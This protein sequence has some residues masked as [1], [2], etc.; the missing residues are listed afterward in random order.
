[1]NKIKTR[2]IKILLI[3][4]N[5]VDK[6][7]QEITI[8]M[9]LFILLMQLYPISI[10]AINTFSTNASTTI[11]DWGLSFGEANTRPRGNVSQKELIKYNSY[12]IG[13]E[14]EKEKIIY[15]TFDAGYENGN[16]E[17][18]LNI[19]KEEE[20]PAA[21]FLVGHY[22]NT[23]PELVKRMTEDGH[24]VGNHT[25][26]HPDMSKISDIESLKAELEP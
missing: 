24:I 3:I 8:C 6:R 15:L 4:R 22:F 9:L 7:W 10:R 2:I 5:F 11:T 21:F 25:S 13:S 17:K 18:I 26:S 1:M 14:K 23:N 16:T 19:L 12:F 20:V